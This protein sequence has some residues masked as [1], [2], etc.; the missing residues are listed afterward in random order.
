MTARARGPEVY[1]RHLERALSRVRQT[2]VV[3][4][5]RDWEL[6]VDWH[7]REIPLAVIQEALEE[8]AARARKRG[9]SGPRSL[10]YLARAVDEAWDLIRGGRVDPLDGEPPGSPSIAD[11]REAWIRARESAGEGSPLATL[12]RRLLRRLDDG[13]APEEIDRELERSILDA[14]SPE[15]VERIG[16]EVAAELA[17]VRERIRAGHLESTS[18]R[19]TVTRL[20]RSLGLPRLSTESG[21]EQGSPL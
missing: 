11:V 1:A 20:R 10:T 2:P 17:P 4:S 7:A 15:L 3:L 12:I 18:R 9:G 14:A 13:E 16:G 6:V 5:P 19:A 8:A 21:N